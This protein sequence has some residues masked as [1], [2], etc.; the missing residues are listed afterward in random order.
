LVSLLAA[1]ISDVQDA[2]PSVASKGGVILAHSFR[3]SAA[4]VLLNRSVNSYHVWALKLAMLM[5]GVEGPIK[6]ARQD[7]KE[8]QR[9]SSFCRVWEL[10]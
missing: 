7:A 6:G 10:R 9:Y 3:I 5:S 1:L 4:V 8:Y 2:R